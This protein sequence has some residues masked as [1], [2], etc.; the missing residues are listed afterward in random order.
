MEVNE[1][2]YYIGLIT[3]G[4]IAFHIIKS[5]IRIIRTI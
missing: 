3:I 1:L 2:V 5:V 4:L